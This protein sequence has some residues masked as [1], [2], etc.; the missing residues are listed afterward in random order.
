MVILRSPKGWTGP[1]AVDGKKVEDFWRAHQVPVSACRENE[2]HRQILEEWMRSYQPDDLF[3]TAGCLKPELKALAPAGD[4]R[5][6]ASP[7]A[8][9][10]LL[11]CELNVPDIRYLHTRC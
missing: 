11:R 6:G 8:N 1:A 4:K 3:D 2:D 10:V 9:G 5:M 7:Y